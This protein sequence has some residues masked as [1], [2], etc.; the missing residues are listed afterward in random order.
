M[1]EISVRNELHDPRCVA[2]TFRP[3]GDLDSQHM[4][5]RLEIRPKH[6]GARI[7]KATAELV[8]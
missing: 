3:I 4:S 1:N 7:M 8:I 2:G 6:H 5:P